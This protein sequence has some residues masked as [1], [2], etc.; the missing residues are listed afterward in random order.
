VFLPEDFIYVDSGNSGPKCSACHDGNDRAEQ[1]LSSEQKQEIQGLKDRLSCLQNL[2]RP[3]AS[4]LQDE[5]DLGVQQLTRYKMV[6][7]VEKFLRRF[8]D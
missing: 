8:D 5:S 1:E 7:S 2:T 6:L 3:L 4:H